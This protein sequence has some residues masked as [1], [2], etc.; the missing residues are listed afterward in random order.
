[1]TCG[2]VQEGQ[3]E[4]TGMIEEDRYTDAARAKLGLPCLSHCW[5]QV[6]MICVIP[7]ILVLQCCHCGKKREEQ[8]KSLRPDGC[9][10]KG[11]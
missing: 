5:H 9:E 3:E 2:K 4:G 8:T 7:P 10:W 1:M 11:L 6:E